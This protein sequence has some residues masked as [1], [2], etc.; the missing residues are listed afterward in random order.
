[1]KNLITFGREPKRRGKNFPQQKLS[2]LLNLVLPELTTPN[3]NGGPI[4]TLEYA[5]VMVGVVSGSGVA[6]GGGGQGANY[7][8]APPIRGI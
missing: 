1:M 5:V 6:R 2:P 3:S 4:L 8:M 7:H